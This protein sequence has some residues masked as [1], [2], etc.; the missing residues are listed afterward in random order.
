MRG[1]IQSAKSWM[2]KTKPVQVPG[3]TVIPMVIPPSPQAK[4]PM[5]G[6]FAE[7]A[8]TKDPQPRKKR[9][10][11]FS[12]DD[13]MDARSIDLSLLGAGPELK[14][15]VRGT[16]VYGTCP[17]C[18]STWNLRERLLHPKFRQSD[19]PKGLTC[20]NCDESV[21]VPTTLDPRRMLA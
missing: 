17:H 21:S 13:L 9:V 8:L 1:L 20:P 19:G 4:S 10:R 18:E 6:P 14:V 12:N 2:K 15:L 11:K 5:E 16:S 3:H 7:K